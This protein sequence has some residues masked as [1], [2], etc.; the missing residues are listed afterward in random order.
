VSELGCCAFKKILGRHLT[1]NDSIRTFQKFHDQSHQV[2]VPWYK[3]QSTTL[4]SIVRAGPRALT[5]SVD[6]Q[7]GHNMVVDYLLQHNANPNA[8]DIKGETPLH[9]AAQYG[10][11]SVW[12]TLLKH[13]ADPD[14][15]DLKGVCVQHNM[16]LFYAARY[17]AAMCHADL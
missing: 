14:I 1:K 13:G 5:R 11:G 10:S 12:T 9:K 6:L 15:K 2:F 17:C 4:Y 16:A 8:R 7:G 3:Q